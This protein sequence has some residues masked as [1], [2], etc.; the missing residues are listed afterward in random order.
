MHNRYS[1]L[2]LVLLMI[3]SLTSCLTLNTR[4]EH[5]S[6]GSGKL[7]LEYR[8]DKKAIG[9]QKN[10]LGDTALIP[11]PVNR[12]DFEQNALL[13]SEIVLK[14]YEER[15]D[16]SYVYIKAELD[17]QNLDELCRFLN[18]P[19]NHKS[20]GTENSLTFTFL[21]PGTKLDA[22]TLN[23]IEALF[24]D[25]SLKFDF[26]FPDNIKSSTYGKVTGNQVSYQTSLNSVYEKGAEGFVWTISW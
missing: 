2:F 25:D 1:L 18:I 9:V 21:E 12:S 14:N 20:S 22:D 16:E 15:E 10:A 3:F 6:S 19:G 26:S 7:F 4:L 24:A 17:Y 11:L 23:I 5:G 8:L 13:F